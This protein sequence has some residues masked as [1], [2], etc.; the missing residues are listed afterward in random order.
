MKYLFLIF[1]LVLVGCNSSEQCEISVDD[2]SD[3]PTCYQGV[4]LDRGPGCIATVLND[5]KVVTCEYNGW[6]E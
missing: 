2:R 5:D 1:S 3:L 4:V 6:S